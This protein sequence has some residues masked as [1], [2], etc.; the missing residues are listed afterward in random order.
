MAGSVGTLV[1]ANRA[2][3]HLAGVL[4]RLL[5]R[6][7][8]GQAARPIAVARHAAVQM[9]T[10][11]GLAVVTVEVHTRAGVLR[12]RT[13]PL[14]AAPPLPSRAIKP[15]P[16]PTVRSGQTLNEKRWGAG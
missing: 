7:Q 6:Q 9:A 10:M 11:P 16:E 4:P 12:S 8:L 1:P 13:R 2:P 5:T 15:G 14:G 3:A